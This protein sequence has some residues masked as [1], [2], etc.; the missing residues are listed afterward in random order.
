MPNTSQ[1]GA[2]IFGIS[3]TSGTNPTL[4]IYKP[5]GSDF[6]TAY[7]SPN[8]S[9]VS[10]QHAVR[11]EPIIGDAGDPVAIIG[12]GDYLEA[13]FECIPFG[14]TTANARKSAM[15][16]PTGSSVVTTGFDI[17]PQ[18]PFADGFNVNAGGA[19]PETSRWLYFGGGS[20]KIS[21]DGKA[22]VS[23]PLK[24]YPKIVGGVA[25]VD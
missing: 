18:G 3:S 4:Q 17:I 25:I 10:V 13:T 8:I 9:G 19:A 1:G 20:I 15:L 22:T 2:V 16:P 11:S 21:S 6:L 7:V 5:D 14:T 23:L 24:R 12:N